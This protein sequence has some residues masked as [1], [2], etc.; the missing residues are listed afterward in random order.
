MLLLFRVTLVFLTGAV[1]YLVAFAILGHDDKDQ[2]TAE[3]V[4]DFSVRMLSVNYHYISIHEK[5][6]QWELSEISI[7]SP[8][9][10]LSNFSWVQWVFFYNWLSQLMKKIL[11]EDQVRFQRVEIAKSL[12]KQWCNLLTGVPWPFSD[13][14]YS[15]FHNSCKIVTECIVLSRFYRW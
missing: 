3:S 9:V 15:C 2:L 1:S 4:K 11:K 6:F 10:T 12:R 13:E 7:I 8:T 5:T 14:I